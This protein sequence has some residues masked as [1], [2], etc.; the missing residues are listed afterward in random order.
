M[1]DS[2][3]KYARAKKPTLRRR[4]YRNSPEYDPTGRDSSKGL[5]G[6][7]L[8]QGCKWKTSRVYPEQLWSRVARGIAAVEQTE[9]KR[10]EWGKLFYEALTNF[11]FVPGG[12]ILAGAGTGHQVTYYNCFSGDTLVHTRQGLIPIGTL[13]GE[14][15]VLSDGGMYRTACFK[16]YGKAATLGSDVIKRCYYLYD[17]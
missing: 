6:P 2:R 10:E 5:H 12:R 15:E 8:P 13:D 9:E 14:H 11:Q 4:N 7:I 3:S 17:R 16:S 1:I